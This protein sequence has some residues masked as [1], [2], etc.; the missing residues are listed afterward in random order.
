[1]LICDAIDRAEIVRML[2][3][4]EL[5]PEEEALHFIIGK[6][7]DPSELNLFLFELLVLRVVFAGSSVA[8][9]PR[10]L[11]I[12]IELESLVDLRRRDGPRARRL[13]IGQRSTMVDAVPFVM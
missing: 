6:V 11:R 8:F 13:G 3:K 2:H 9:L 10:D 4:P 12:F 5:E 1:M 7:T